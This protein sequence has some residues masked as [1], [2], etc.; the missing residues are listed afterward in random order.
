MF[1]RPRPRYVDLDRLPSRWHLPPGRYRGPAGPYAA[2]TFL[3]LPSPSEPV[4]LTQHTT[5]VGGVRHVNRVV[6]PLSTVDLIGYPDP[7]TTGTLASLVAALRGVGHRSTDTTTR[8]RGPADPVL[9]EALAVPVGTPA[10]G[11]VRL[12]LDADTWRPLALADTLTLTCPRPLPATSAERR[13]PAE[14]LRRFATHR[15]RSR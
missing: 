3:H 11:M 7:A 13:R 12:L 10:A 9:A 4:L 14:L 6:V 15:D 8:T 2:G 1:R 5:T